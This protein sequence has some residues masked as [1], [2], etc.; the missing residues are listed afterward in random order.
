MSYLLLVILIAVFWAP[1]RSGS[2][3]SNPIEL[4]LA[5]LFDHVRENL[6]A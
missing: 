2:T 4:L 3:P 5:L 6:T 1:L